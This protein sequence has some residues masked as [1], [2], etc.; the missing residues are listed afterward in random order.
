MR[1]VLKKCKLLAS[2]SGRGQ[3]KHLLTHGQATSHRQ[4]QSIHSTFQLLNLL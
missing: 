4:Q 2:L 1:L 3:E